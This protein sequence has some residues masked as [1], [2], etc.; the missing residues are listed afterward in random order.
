MERSGPTSFQRQQRVLRLQLSL[1]EWR[2]KGCK[3]R[4]FS[5]PHV[6]PQSQNT[7]LGHLSSCQLSLPA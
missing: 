5:P 3:R 1:S 6:S 2:C 4:G 7:H